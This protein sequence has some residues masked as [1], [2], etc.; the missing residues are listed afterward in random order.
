MP[1][2]GHGHSSS[3]G[4]MLG[5]TTW[6]WLFGILPFSFSFV[7]PVQSGVSLEVLRDASVPLASIFSV[8]PTG[9]STLV[10]FPALP[11]ISILAFLLLQASL[12]YFIKGPQIKFCWNTAMHIHL[13]IA[14]A[15]FLLQ[16][17]G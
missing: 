7:G 5:T 9:H 10:D 4:L 8:P 11:K 12:F 3:D 1:C 14:I 2:H 13:Y 6:L 16:G 17:P 15:A